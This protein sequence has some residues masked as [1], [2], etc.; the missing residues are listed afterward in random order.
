MR[1]PDG[2]TGPVWRGESSMHV[3]REEGG[4]LWAPCVAFAPERAVL[5]RI[6]L[7]AR[8]TGPISAFG[9]A[10]VP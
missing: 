5:P 9:H 6:W 1:P 8:Q 10:S 4:A 2:N 7:L 3:C